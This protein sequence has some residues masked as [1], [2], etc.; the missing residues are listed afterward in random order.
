MKYG[1]MLQTLSL[2]IVLALLIIAMPATPVR[3]QDIVDVDPSDGEI[4]DRITVTGED[5]DPGTTVWVYFS[6]DD[7]DV[8]DDIDDEVT[9][10]EKYF[11]DVGDNGED[12]E[13]EFE[14]RFNIPEELLD[15]DDEAVVSGGRYYI[16]VAYSDDEILDR[17][18]FT[19]IGAEIFLDPDEGTVGTEVE[20]EGTD[21]NDREDITVYYDDDEI[22]IEDGDEDTD[23]RGELITTIIIPEGIAGN[24]TIRVE[25][26]AGGVAETVFTVEPEITVGEESGEAGTRIPLE[27]TGFG[28]RVTVEIYFD[29]DLVETETTNRDG[30]FSTTFEV[31]DEAAG[32]YDL[33]A[34]DEDNNEAEAVE[35]EIEAEEIVTSAALNPMTGNIGTDLTVSGTGFTAGGQVTVRYDDTQVAT[36]TADSQGIFSSTFK[37]PDSK[38]GAHTVT[39]SDGTISQQ[40]TFTM[41]STPPPIPAPL[42]PY[43]GVEVEQPV[44]FD[45]K[46]VTDP[47]G[48]TYTL[49]IAK[50]DRFTTTSLVLERQGLS[51]SE[52]TL[53]QAEELAPTEEEAPYYWRVMAT[54]GAANE[55]EWTTPGT[56]YITGGSVITGTS[57]GLPSWLQYLLFGLGGLLLLGIGYWLGRRTAYY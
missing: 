9:H 54:D 29:G 45:W 36:V 35:F 37:A 21:F 41:E 5:F 16:Y 4:G 30:S 25:D 7:A 46:D 50:D 19:V 48:A 43:N 13:G 22:D 31:P 33:T 44:G 18:T 28:R 40:L 17:V 57:E 49:Q 24:Y 8:G 27:G 11:A 6:S 10:Y 55:S 20:I 52:Y 56:F 1:K 34:E 42:L 53:S 14:R 32:T 23:S 26:D 2:V 15:G 47:S 3:A 39:V 38:S 12:D 51:S